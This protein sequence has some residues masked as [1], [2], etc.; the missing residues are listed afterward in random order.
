VNLQLGHTRAHLARAVMEGAAFELRLALE[1]LN[2]AGMP[3]NELWMVGGATRSPLWPCLVAEVT[4]LPLRVTRTANLPAAGAAMLAGWGAGL[5][6]SLAEAQVRFRMASTHITPDPVREE[7][8]SATFSR[9]VE[10]LHTLALK[11]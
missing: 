2:R 3:V 11:K 8:Y 6:G 9:Y 1:S 5:F 7:L 4:G 10:A